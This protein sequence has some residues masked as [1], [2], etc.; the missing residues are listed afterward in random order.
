MTKQKK[1]KNVTTHENKPIHPRKMI[2][3]I[4]IGVFIA[5]LLPAIGI[6]TAVAV[7]VGLLVMGLSLSIVLRISSKKQNNQNN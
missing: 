1:K 3:P 6:P 5:M 7:T 4:M 2:V